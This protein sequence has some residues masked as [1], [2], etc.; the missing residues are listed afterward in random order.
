VP[1]PLPLCAELASQLHEPLSNLAAVEEMLKAS[2]DNE[3]LVGMRDMLQV[4]I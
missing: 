3:E 1:L 2:P 4:P